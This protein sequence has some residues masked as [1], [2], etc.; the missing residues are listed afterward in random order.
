MTYTDL[1]GHHPI[2]C[3]TKTLI[4]K[5][6]E[7]LWDLKLKAAQPKSEIKVNHYEVWMAVK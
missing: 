5:C 3:R 6:F 7:I 1:F 2:K 4:Q